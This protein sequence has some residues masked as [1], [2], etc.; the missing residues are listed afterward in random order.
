MSNLSLREF[1]DWLVYNTTIGLVHELHVSA[2]NPVAEE[3]K[4]FLTALRQG[5]Q[6]TLSGIASEDALLLAG[7]LNDVYQ[8]KVPALDALALDKDALKQE[9]QEV[10]AIA[11]QD[12]GAINTYDIFNAPELPTAPALKR[13]VPAYD[14]V[15]LHVIQMFTHI[16]DVA[17]PEIYAPTLKAITDFVEGG[18]DVDVTK[19]LSELEA[20]KKVANRG[21][22]NNKNERDAMYGT[23]VDAITKAREAPSCEQQAVTITGNLEGAS[24]KARIAAGAVTKELVDPVVGPTL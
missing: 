17:E 1:N 6:D 12:V 21:C 9:I 11:A 22:P 18:S 4:A 7:W 23:V 3:D 20:G 10:K 14:E 24:E 15:Q 19:I 13:P 16:S 5:L 8:T 2:E